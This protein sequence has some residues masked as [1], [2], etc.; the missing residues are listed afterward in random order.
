MSQRLTEASYWGKRAGHYKIPD[1]NQTKKIKTLNA[2]H[3]LID[4]EEARLQF[5]EKHLRQMLTAYNGDPLIKAKYAEYLSK[6]KNKE[7]PLGKE[8]LNRMESDI[9]SRQLN[10]T[11]TATYD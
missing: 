5:F 4:P 8:F 7:E 2:E 6:A 9:R 10:H 3:F 11:T 1:E